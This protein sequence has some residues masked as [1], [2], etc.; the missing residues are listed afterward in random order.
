MFFAL[1]LALSSLPGPIFAVAIATFLV[2]RYFKVRSSQ[3]DM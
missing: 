1:S 2:V 3:L